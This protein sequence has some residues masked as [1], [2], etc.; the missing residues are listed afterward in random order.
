MKL[1][2]EFD[3]RYRQE[4]IKSI[5]DLFAGQPMEETITENQST[6]SS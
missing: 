5:T 1:T 2:L 4:A 3:L 6:L